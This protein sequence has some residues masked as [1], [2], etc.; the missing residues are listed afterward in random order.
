MNEQNK[1]IQVKKEETP[2]IKEGASTTSA[3]PSNG[4]RRLLSKKWAFPAIYMAAAAIILTF[5]WVYQ[6]MGKTTH[7]A[8]KTAA[9][10]SKTGTDAAVQTDAS[11]NAVPVIANAENMQWPVKDRSQVV[12]SLPFYDS[13]ASNEVKQAAMVQYGDTFTPHTGIDLARQDNQAFDVLAALSG[14]VTIVEKNPIAGN[15]VEITHN[16]GL[17]TVYQ[18]LSNIKVAQGAT[19]KKGDV[20]ATAGVN[21][22]EKDD[23]VHVH[24]EVRQGKDGPV[25]NPETLIT[26]PGK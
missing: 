12:T 2:Q 17:I 4:W 26:E 24:F 15:L 19:V 5:V 10:A 16:N 1:G 20:I 22:L 9:T 14:T 6:D 8:D 7:T 13:K 25:I 18:S 3:D 11:G 21:E 23:G